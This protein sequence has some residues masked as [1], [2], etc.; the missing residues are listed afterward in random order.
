MYVYGFER[1]LHIKAQEHQ[2]GEMVVMAVKESSHSYQIYVLHCMHGTE[3][4]WPSERTNMTTA[5]ACMV[6]IGQDSNNNRAALCSVFRSRN[7]IGPPQREC[8]RRGMVHVIK[9]AADGREE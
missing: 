8:T 1:F 6:I 2:T 9:V 5:I 4:W 7:A 3:V